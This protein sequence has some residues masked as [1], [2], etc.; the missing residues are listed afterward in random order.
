LAALCC[1]RAAERRERTG[2]GRTAVA[3][4]GGRGASITLPGRATA[5]LLTRSG[6]SR[7]A[8]WI[9]TGTK[10]LAL[11]VDAFARSNE[12]LANGGRC[13]DLEGPDWRIP[14]F[15]LRRGLEACRALYDSRLPTGGSA[16][17]SQPP[18]PESEPQPV[19]C[20]FCTHSRQIASVN[21]IELAPCAQNKVSLIGRRRCKDSR[22]TIRDDLS[23]VSAAIS[24]SQER[25]RQ[26]DCPGRTC[27]PA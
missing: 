27:W 4:A 9:P 3:R 23:N 15:A 25:A 20:L 14:M 16:H 19:I 5:R 17:L 26:F 21:S 8:V 18:A 24:S 7:F 12:G 6:G 2:S 11:V 10:G 13:F 22:G 1:N